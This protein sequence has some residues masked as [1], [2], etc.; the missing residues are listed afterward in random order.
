MAIPR[1]TRIQHLRRI[2]QFWDFARALQE[3]HCE[4]HAGVPSNMTMHEPGS[5]VIRLECE[6]EIST[7]WQRGYVS[8]WGVVKIVCGNGGCGI[9]CGGLLAHDEEIVAVEMDGMG[10]GE[11]AVDNEVDPFICVRDFDEI[12]RSPECGDVVLNHEKSW[13][14]PFRKES[15]V[16][17]IP[18]EKFLG[19]LSNGNCFLGA[20]RG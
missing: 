18:F 5:G 17:E 9:E 4:S 11:S 8:S 16:V 15:G 13:I 12:V 3:L 6:N 14:F 2:Q 1:R 20:F 7:S 10:N 19:I